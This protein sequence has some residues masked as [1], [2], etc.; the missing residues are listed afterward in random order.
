MTAIATAK[1]GNV[2][3]EMYHQTIGQDVIRV[4]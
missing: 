1:N 2:Y 4:F 3:K